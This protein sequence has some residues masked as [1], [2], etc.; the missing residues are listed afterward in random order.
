MRFLHG[1][2]DALISA[3]TADV[4]AHQFTDTLGIVARLAFRDEP[5]GAHDLAGRA[6]AALEGIVGDEG[7]L[8]RMKLAALGEPFDGGDLGAVEAGSER[9]AGIDA[10][11][12]DQHS[13]GATLSAVTPLLAAGEIQALPQ[14]VEQHHAW[15]LELDCART[16][17]D[18]EADGE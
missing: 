7:R 14:Q 3:A 5:H 15:I 4:A 8:D 12:V 17:I 11:P 13:T 9:E 16:T 1:L 2:G 10:S 6:I 18:D